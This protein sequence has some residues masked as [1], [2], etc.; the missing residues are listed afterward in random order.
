M[1][2]EN[3][4]TFVS[5]KC[6]F[7]DYK[8]IYKAQDKSLVLRL[9]NDVLDEVQEVESSPAVQK[10]MFDATGETTVTRQFNGQ[11]KDPVTGRFINKKQE[12][13]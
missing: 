3:E 11:P 5:R 10:E 6:S 8:E 1:N 9:L 7:H 12:E 4:K 2:A 13:E